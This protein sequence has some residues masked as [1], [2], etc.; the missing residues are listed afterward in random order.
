MD[1]VVRRP[2]SSLDAWLREEA[3]L[4]SAERAWLVGVD[5]EPGVTAELS[6]GLRGDD[7]I[8]TAT[9]LVEG[10]AGDFQGIPLLAVRWLALD[11]ASRDTLQ[12]LLRVDFHAD[13]PQSDFALPPISSAS[14]MVVP[15]ADPSTMAIESGIESVRSEPVLD[16]VFAAR[17]PVSRSPSAPASLTGDPL[18]RLRARAVSLDEKQRI[19]RRGR[20]L[21]G[22]GSEL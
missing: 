18:M 20:H 6:I 21:R 11:D 16:S 13:A 1:L 7:P 2:Y 5:A 14:P 9:V 10:I 22:G 3:H 19:L 8:L 17:F 4:F 12:T 15:L